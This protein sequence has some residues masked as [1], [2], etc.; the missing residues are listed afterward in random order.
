MMMSFYRHTKLNK[1]IELIFFSFYYLFEQ[2][3]LH[4]FTIWEQ[5]LQF[6]AHA[7]KSFWHSILAKEARSF[8]HDTIFLL[9]SRLMAKKMPNTVHW[10]YLIQAK[11]TSNWY[12]RNKF[13]KLQI[14]ASNRRRK[15]YMKSHE[16]FLND[17]ISII[18]RS[19][20]KSNQSIR[21]KPMRSVKSFANFLWIN[22]LKSKNTKVKKFHHMICQCC[23][24]WS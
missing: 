3:E 23:S 14:L 7:V 22:G 10:N 12:C 13:I 19:E 5:I 20:T 18:I 6:N 15:K 17:S 11:K 4:A 21:L 1:K 24:T 16:Y 2:Y 8:H 9:R